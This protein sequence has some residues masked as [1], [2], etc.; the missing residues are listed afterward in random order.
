MITIVKEA[1][2]LLGPFLTLIWLLGTLCSIFLVSLTFA[3]VLTRFL[4]LERVTCLVVK[5]TRLSAAT[6]A[7]V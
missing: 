7:E 2:T 4:R 6:S 1:T 3:L 5:Y